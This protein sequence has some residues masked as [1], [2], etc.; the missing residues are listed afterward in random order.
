MPFNLLVMG[1]Y[2]QVL[3]GGEFG[4]TTDLKRLS[5]EQGTELGSE[6]DRILHSSSVVWFR[7]RQFGEDLDV[8]IRHQV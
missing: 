1:W 5:L 7:F 2:E 3:R 4:R 6:V 8:C